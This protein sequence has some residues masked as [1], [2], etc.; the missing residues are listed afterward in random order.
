MNKY[1]FKRQFK[2]RNYL[3]IIAEDGSVFDFIDS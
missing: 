2:R 1:I 3:E